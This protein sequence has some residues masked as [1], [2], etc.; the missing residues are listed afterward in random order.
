MAK[1]N[2]VRIDNNP[3][4]KINVSKIKSSTTK[5]AMDNPWMI[6]SVILGVIAL[7][8]LYMVMTGSNGASSSSISE[9]AASEKVLEFLNAQVGGGVEYVS[10]EDKGDLYEVMVSFQG[11]DLPVYVT[12]DGEYFVQGAV[13]FDEEEN[14]PATTPS[15]NTPSTNTPP[16]T[17]TVTKS[18]K[19]E[20][21]LFV[22]SHCPYGTQAMKGM[23]PVLELLEGKIDGQIKFVYYA[24]HGDKEIYEQLNQYC[25]YEEQK[26]VY[27]D[28]MKCFL[29]SDGSESGAAA[30]LDEAKVDKGDLKTCTDAADTKFDITKNF[31][32]KGSW[33]SGRYPK[34]DIHAD[35]NTKYGVG[36]SPTLVVN[37]AQVQSARDSASYLST[38]CAAFNEAPEECLEDLSSYGTPGPGFGYDSQGGAAAA[39]CG[40]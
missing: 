20:V 19:P 3:D 1:S 18:D 26:D 33:L 23:L 5:T 4:K 9:D 25:I 13:S 36:G 39:G 29:G 24:M 30:C 28:Y 34:F 22:M 10:M 2:E 21:E 17:P 14:A 27:Y 32:D 31:D 38:I 40:I 35:L 8:L 16:P 6:A 37:G 12:K 15:T 11:Q 7:A